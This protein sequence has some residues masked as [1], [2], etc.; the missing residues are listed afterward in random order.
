MATRF[1][2]QQTFVAKV[3]PLSPMEMAT[4]VIGKGTINSFDS[5]FY[6]RCSPKVL[7]SDLQNSVATLSPL[8]LNWDL[9]L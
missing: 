6:R 1:Y 2:D 5:T 4:M 8:C 7:V 3:T 9:G